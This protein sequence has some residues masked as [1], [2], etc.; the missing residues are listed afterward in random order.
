MDH[1][2][3]TLRSVRGPNFRFAYWSKKEVELR[4][5]SFLLFHFLKLSGTVPRTERSVVEGC[6][7]FDEMDKE[8]IR[9]MSE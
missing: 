8:K 2:S 7:W 9:Q 1:P 6:E 3:T 4:S 5:T